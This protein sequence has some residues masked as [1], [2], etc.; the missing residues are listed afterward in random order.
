MISHWHCH[1]TFF[2]WIFQA[3][4]YCCPC[5][6]VYRNAEDMNKS[7]ILYCLLSC[8]MPCIPI[9]L[10]RG[11]ARDKYNI[12]VS[13]TK[14]LLPSFREINKVCCFE[15]RQFIL[16][17]MISSIQCTF[18]MT[19]QASLMKVAW[20]DFHWM[21][22][23]MNLMDASQVQKSHVNRNYLKIDDGRIQG[24]RARRHS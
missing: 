4:A 9:L 17:V 18:A 1:S 7:G 20:I 8:I 21:E 16:N 11:E 12:E 13:K 3:C 24:N 22:E 23:S 10:L 6:L 15:L 2:S 14:K 5:C 19:R